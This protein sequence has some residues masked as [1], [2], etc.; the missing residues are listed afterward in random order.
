MFVENGE[1]GSSVAGPV[2]KRISDAWLLDILRLDLAASPEPL[3]EQRPGRQ[4]EA[5]AGTDEAIASGE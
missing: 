1:S 2:A 5:V 3:P 4:P